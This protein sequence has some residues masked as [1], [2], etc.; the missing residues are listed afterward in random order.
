MSERAQREAAAADA[1]T[2]EHLPVIP[3]KPLP[4]RRKRGRPKGSKNKPSK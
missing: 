2:A 1:E 4:P 3:E